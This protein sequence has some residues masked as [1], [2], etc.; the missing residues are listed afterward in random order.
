MTSDAAYQRVMRVP[1]RQGRLFTEADRRGA[2]LVVLINETMARLHFAGLDPIGRRLAFDRVPDSTSVWRTVVGVIGDERQVSLGA[3]VAPEIFAPFEQDSRR[4]MTLVVRTAGPPRALIE[5]VGAIVADLDD[6][7]AISTVRTMA[8]VRAISLGRERFL[9]M[10]LLSFA[11]VG[12]VLSL[13][14]VYGV[15]SE[16][17]RRRV[18]EMGVRLAVGASPAG[19]RWLIVRHGL[20]MSTLGIAVGV[21]IAFLAT[22]LLRSLLYQVA[23]SDPAT[24]IAVPALVLAT[25]LAASWLPGHRAS[26]TDPAQVLRQD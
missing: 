23:P 5:P 7:L 26:R 11:G 9:T 8:D 15:G 4:A 25:A 3:E 6:K 17:A 16:L 24:F 19:V 22:G 10:L 2:P 13:V 14:G 1:L 20:A 21:A 18:R 12:L